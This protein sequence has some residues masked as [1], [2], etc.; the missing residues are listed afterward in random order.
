MPQT[1]LQMLLR[2]SFIKLLCCGIVWLCR[3]HIINNAG[4]WDCFAIQLGLDLR[5]CHMMKPVPGLS[6][7]ED[8]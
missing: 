1:F 4:N 7:C 8:G 6:V 5:L 3:S 2:S